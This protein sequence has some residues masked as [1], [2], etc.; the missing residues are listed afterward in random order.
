MTTL[1]RKP[2]RTALIAATAPLTV[3]AAALAHPGHD[4]SHWTSFGIHGLF[5][6]GMA[7]V[8]AAVVWALSRQG[9]RAAQAMD[10]H[11]DP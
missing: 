2:G 5:L 10:K 4:H 7:A 11:S 3:P 1:S 9:R 6:V 8:C